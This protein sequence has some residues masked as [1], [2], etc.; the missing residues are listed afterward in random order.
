MSDPYAKLE[1]PTKEV[2][3]EKSVKELAEELK[4][5][6]VEHDNLRYPSLDNVG[7]A[8]A[9]LYSMFMTWADLDVPSE[10][11]KKHLSA[12]ISELQEKMAVL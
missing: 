8:Y 12:K 3:M 7:N 10:R 1:L 6:M 2:K 5:L 4:V 9:V 11:I